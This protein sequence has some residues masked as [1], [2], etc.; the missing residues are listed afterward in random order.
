M[1]LNQLKGIPGARKIR[2]RVGRGLG[3]G[4]GE[5]GGRGIKG[6]KSRSGVVINGFEGG[7]MPVHMRLPKRGF[8][9]VRP[10]SFNLINLSQ[11]QSAV[12]GGKLDAESAIT[13][14][15][16]IEAGV[17]RRKKDGIRILGNGRI[18]ARVTLHV[19][20]ASKSAVVEVEKAGGK[21]VLLK[22]KAEPGGKAKA[23]QDKGE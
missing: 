13:S 4:L 19:Q 9:P 17:I 23:N 11:L 8:K 20:G 16:L 15:T 2:K 22:G 14:D 7:Q 12:D 21:I 10:K 1:K 6:Q 5:T 3:S 18:K